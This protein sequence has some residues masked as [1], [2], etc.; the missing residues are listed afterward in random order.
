MEINY[1]KPR[2]LCHIL[3]VCVRARN[4]GKWERKYDCICGKILLSMCNEQLS[5]VSFQQHIKI[6]SIFIYEKKWGKIKRFRFSSLFIKLYQINITFF[7]HLYYA[8]NSPNSNVGID[9]I[10]ITFSYMLKVISFQ[11]L[12]EC[13]PLRIFNLEKS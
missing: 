1:E 10:E 3:F 8:S 5:W 9:V 4:I 13:V 6:C 12:T 11:D 2:K 7:C